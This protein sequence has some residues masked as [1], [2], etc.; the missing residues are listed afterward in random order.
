M[1]GNRSTG[2]RRQPNK[3]EGGAMKFKKSIFGGLV[4]LPLVGLLSLTGNSGVMAAPPEETLLATTTADDH[5]AAARYY[6]NEAR[7][8]AAEAAEFRAAVAK[9][10]PYDDPKGL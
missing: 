7:E 3:E 10:G 4:M 6:Q 9:I 1:S 2:C 8:A 5:L